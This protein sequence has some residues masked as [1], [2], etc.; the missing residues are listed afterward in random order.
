MAIS[1]SNRQLKFRATQDLIAILNYLN[2]IPTFGLSDTAINAITNS[3]TT[4]KL[5]TAIAALT[6]HAKHK[7]F[8]ALAPKM[9][10]RC[11]AMFTFT[12]AM[13]DTGRDVQ[14]AGSYDAMIAAILSD[15]G[16]SGLSA[17]AQPLSVW[18]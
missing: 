9:I 1:K 4:A 6:L 11:V 10:D 16:V 18:A 13:V 2:A 5:K 12:D 7:H 14:G 17:S 15:S 8:Q 3:G